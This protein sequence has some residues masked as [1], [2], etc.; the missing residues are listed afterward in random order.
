[1]HC[2]VLIL[3]KI[4]DKHDMKKRS[5]TIRKV[6]YFYVMKVLLTIFSGMTSCVFKILETKRFVKTYLTSQIILFKHPKS[7]KFTKKH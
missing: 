4:D 6:L 7:H 1:M 5:N 2:V 3:S